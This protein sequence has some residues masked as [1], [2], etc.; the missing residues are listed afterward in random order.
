MSGKDVFL[1]PRLVLQQSDDLDALGILLTEGIEHQIIR[2]EIQGQLIGSAGQIALDN[3]VTTL[4]AIRGVNDHDDIFPDRNE[5]VIASDPLSEDDLNTG[6]P[7]VVM[8]NEPFVT[9]PPEPM[10]EVEGFTIPDTELLTNTGGDQIHETDINDLIF[11]SDNIS[12]TPSENQVEPSEELLD[13]GQSIL[14][15]EIL[16]GSTAAQITTSDGRTFLGTSGTIEI[17]DDTAGLLMGVIGME[18][19]DIPS[20]EENFLGQCGEISCIQQ[21]REDN[22]ANGQP[23]DFGLD[24]A[25]II[26]I[27]VRD[28]ESARSFGEPKDPCTACNIIGSELNISINGR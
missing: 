11:T 13:F 23:I 12:I 2:L 24:G 19:V 22:L 17:N 7:P 26:I 16:G 28:T 25:S 15:G 4:N 6:S 20:Q 27:Q 3:F 9:L 21:V 8:D 5:T 18:G 10:E 1:P 14:D